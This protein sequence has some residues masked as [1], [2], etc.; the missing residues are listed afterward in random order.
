MF[1]AERG[2]YFPW[3]ILSFRKLQGAAE[4]VNGPGW[5]ISGTVHEQRTG[6]STFLLGLLRV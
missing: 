4:F 5:A 3:L 2:F 1:E 6:L